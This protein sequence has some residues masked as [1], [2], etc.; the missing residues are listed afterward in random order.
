VA[1]IYRVHRDTGNPR[2]GFCAGATLCVVVKYHGIQN[3]I[4]I[5]CSAYGLRF[6]ILRTILFYGRALECSRFL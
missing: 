5:L 2:Y 3:S 4:K 1:R 6:V